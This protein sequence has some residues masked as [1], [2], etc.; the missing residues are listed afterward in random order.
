[1]KKIPGEENKKKES[2]ILDIRYS[3]E[4]QKQSCI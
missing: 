1:M 2:K 4:N 3:K